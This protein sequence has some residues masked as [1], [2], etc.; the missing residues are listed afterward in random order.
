MMSASA[1][2][3]VRRADILCRWGIVGESSNATSTCV[4]KAGSYR[5]EGTYVVGYPGENPSPSLRPSIALTDAELACG[6]HRKVLEQSRGDGCQAD[7]WL[8]YDV[9]AEKEVP[10]HASMAEFSNCATPNLRRY[11]TAIVVKD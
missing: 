6:P 8:R 5:V 11:Y 2:D 1:P 4:A 9:D 10:I 7:V 3:V